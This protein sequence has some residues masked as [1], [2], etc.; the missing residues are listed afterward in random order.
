MSNQDT[1]E[2]NTKKQNLIKLYPF[3]G[4][5]PYLI[6]K[7]YIIGYNYLTLEKLLIKDIPKKIKEEQKKDF[8]EKEPHEDF[9][10]MEEEP[11]ILNEITNDYKK[12]GLSSKT[13]IQMIFPKKP[14]CHYT[15]EDTNDKAKIVKKKILNDNDLNNFKE[16]TSEK[17]KSENL[18]FSSNPQTGKNSKKS[19]NGIACI[20]YYKFKQKRNIEKRE[21]TYYIPYTFCIISEY[22]Y[23]SS[24]LKLLEFIQI[25][26]SQKS[27]Y[28]P[29]E[30]IIYYIISLSPS[31]LKGDVIMDLNN[32][33]IQETI[34]QQFIKNNIKEEEEKEEKSSNIKIINSTNNIRRSVKLPGQVEEKSKI[35]SNRNSVIIKNNIKK[36]EEEEKNY[37]IEFNYLSGYPLIQYN[38]PKV[39][40]YNLPIDKII[41]IFLF[42]FLEKD[43]LFFS[44][45]IEYLTLTINAYLNLSFPLNDEKYY[46]IGCAISF[47]DFVGGD[48]EFGLKN[49]TS[50][51]G[52]ND[53]Y[54]S[55]YKTKNS[56]F[57]EHLAV[58]LDKGECFY[59]DDPK[60][61][62]KVNENNKKLIKIIEK[63]C[64]ESE[65]HKYKMITL[66]QAINKLS[67]NLKKIYKDT[68]GPST[69]S[70]PSNFLDFKQDIAESN[71][72]IQESFYEFNN[73]LCLYFYENLNVKTDRENQSPENKE[74]D[75][76][77]EDEE[78]EK[79]KDQDLN[80]LF[81]RQYLT[82]KKYNEEE[83][84]FLKELKTTMKYESFVYGFLQSYNPID[85]Y[86]IPLTF[87][88]EFLSIIS[89]KKEQIR[90]ND[91]NI[92]FFSLI[93][94]FYKNS[95]SKVQIN[96]DIH[97]INY[98]K[99]FKPKIDRYIFE[100]NKKRYNYDNTKMVK[101]SHPFENKLIYQT[102]EL[103][104]KILLNYLHISKNLSLEESSPIPTTFPSIEENT[105]NE[106]DI[107]EIET[108][109]ENNCMDQKI[110]TN[111]DI[112]CT[113]ILLL[114]TM[115]LQS[116][117]KTSES[118]EFLSL[119]FQQFTVFR[120]YY[121]ILL[122]M[123]YKLF[124]EKKD[125]KSKIS[126]LALCYY[127]C[128]NSIRNKKLVPNEELMNIIKKFNNIDINQIMFQENNIIQEKEEK[129]E[130]DKI[131]NKN[132]YVFNNFNS[133]RFFSEEIIVK[134]I[135]ETNHDKLNFKIDDVNPKIRFNNGIHKL[136]YEFISQK[137]M[138][139][140]LIA[141]CKK[142]IETL[143]IT[144]LSSEIILSSCLNV[145]IYVRNN[146]EFV[147]LDDIFKALNNIFYSFMYQ[148]DKLKLEKENE[149]I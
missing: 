23:F 30:I 81:D 20:S 126:S 70:S 26:Y 21:Y 122:K 10:E 1:I 7:F 101:I 121:S 36:I 145:F 42:M 55:N 62:D 102:F 79:T 146:K 140:E 143:D 120:K 83:I 24:F 95:N 117:R 87:T 72:K 51:I 86:K 90:R 59:K 19:I 137:S 131:T 78:E 109:I 33:F 110:L 35:I 17:L 34:Y 4:Q 138:L 82:S 149:N 29:I 5:S 40:F 60:N 128:I 114:F 31:P 68:L 124:L 107:A 106:I 56:K 8:K 9:F 76:K 22:P 45:D 37:I 113:N 25:L 13:I 11:S 57:N 104:D 12:E 96:L 39:L 97:I 18:V 43:V 115:C 147:G 129:E 14:K 28:I 27:I 61:K 127:P 75:S 130:K 66:Y 15:W 133:K 91:Y 141:E 47:E 123:I 100:I 49:Y 88:E 46:F 139:N 53:S 112:C 84:L 63:M 93:D 89:R 136:E 41:T 135:N 71:R 74:N 108:C 6:D 103:D 69:K 77:R 44:K 38:L 64:K 3:N 94:G 142:Y 58:D 119:L 80:V 16:I 48:S 50:V 92:N 116:L 32:L 67:I 125:E 118:H 148:F 54:N 85:L 105:L 134:Y 52:I 132:L 144:K 65:N 73:N 111:D 99:Y 2:L 98:F